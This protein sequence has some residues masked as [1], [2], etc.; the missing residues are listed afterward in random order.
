MVSEPIQGE[1]AVRAQAGE[2]RHLYRRVTLHGGISGQEMKK[3]GTV[4]KESGLTPDD[5]A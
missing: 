3:G 2:E 5:R 4:T 1:E